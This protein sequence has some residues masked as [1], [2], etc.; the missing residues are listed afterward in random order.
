MPTHE[1]KKLLMGYLDDELSPDE[2]KKIESHLA[3]C[4]E[5]AEELERYKKLNDI[6]QPL[7]F[8]SNEDRLM[9][10]YWGKGVRKIE[11]K[12]AMFFLFAGLSVLAGFGLVQMTLKVW[13]ATDIPLLIKI[14]IFA[15]LAGGVALLLSILREKLFLSKKQRYSDIRR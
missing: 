8:I 11:R 12:L 9:E 14:S 15:S 4:K 5:C 13:Y 7:D 1:E 6:V 3:E 2:T 10:N